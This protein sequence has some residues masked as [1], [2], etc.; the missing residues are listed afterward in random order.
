M[1]SNIIIK[2]HDGE[3]YINIVKRVI[4]PAFMGWKRREC[5]SWRRREMELDDTILV[6]T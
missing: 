5:L 4:I 3:S 2:Y 6:M 1:I